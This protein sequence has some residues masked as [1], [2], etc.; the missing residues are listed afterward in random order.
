[1]YFQLNGVRIPYSNHTSVDI[2]NIGERDVGL[3]CITDNVNCCGLP[4]RAGEWYY[5]DG[6]RIGP[7]VSGMDFYRGRSRQTVQLHRRN[8]AQGPTG[9]YCCEV[10]ESSQVIQ[11]ICINIVNSK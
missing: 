5:P 11:S 8:N 9:R 2:N 10:P 1:M 7:S 4:N 3:M 6:T